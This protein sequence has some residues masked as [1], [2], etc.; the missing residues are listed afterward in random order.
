LREELFS[1]LHEMKNVTQNNYMTPQN[2][3]KLTAGERR[4]V[5]VVLNVAKESVSK[6]LGRF[7][8]I[9]LQRLRLFCRTCR[10][11]KERCAKIP[12]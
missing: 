4:F 6:L 8:L 12:D 10:L 3:L 9:L 2:V 7:A 5:R 11:I 1:P